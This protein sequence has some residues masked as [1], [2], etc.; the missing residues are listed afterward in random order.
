MI[1]VSNNLTG[2]TA[3]CHLVVGQDNLM[4]PNLGWNVYRVLRVSLASADYFSTMTS[5][6]LKLNG[7]NN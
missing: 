3:T 1:Y 4:A 6:Q 5:F 2:G 7:S